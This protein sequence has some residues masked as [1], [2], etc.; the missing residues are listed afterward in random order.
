M[1]DAFSRCAARSNR[2]DVD[3]RT[4]GSYKVRRMDLY[5]NQRFDD[6]VDCTLKKNCCY[7]VLKA[8]AKYPK[9]PL[10]VWDERL[11]GSRVSAEKD[12]KQLFRG[13]WYTSAGL[14]L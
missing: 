7:D 10:E 8:D 13:T 1:L 4:E 12:L 5:Q 6:L 11:K 9:L 2:K 14:H 3:A